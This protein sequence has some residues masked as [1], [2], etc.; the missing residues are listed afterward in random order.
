MG[1]LIKREVLVGVDNNLKSVDVS[2]ICQNWGVDNRMG[3]VRRIGRH[4]FHIL[5]KH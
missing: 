1:V 2:K 5:K 3:E 4:I